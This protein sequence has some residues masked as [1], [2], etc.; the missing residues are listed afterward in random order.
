MMRINEPCDIILLH[1]LNR[2]ENEKHEASPE[3][4]KLKDRSNRILS[5][6]F[7]ENRMQE[8]GSFSII[9]DLLIQEYK[10]LP[11]LDVEEYKHIKEDSELV[12]G[13]DLSNPRNHSEFS[14]YMLMAQIVMK[15]DHLRSYVP[16]KKEPSISRP[17]SGVSGIAD[18]SR[19]TKSTASNS[20][21]SGTI[22]NG[23]EVQIKRLNKNLS[24]SK[25]HM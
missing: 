23:D 6:L 3:N 11:I 15:L 25:S 2:L 14:N 22:E 18:S 20:K 7:D 1:A 17:V 8:G 10:E 19:D 9:R 21:V 4:I 5:K 24:K 13:R 12:F 16:K